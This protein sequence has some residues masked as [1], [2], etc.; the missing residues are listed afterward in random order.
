MSHLSNTDYNGLSKQVQ[1]SV[2][3]AR[4]SAMLARRVA[5]NINN[6]SS[7]NDVYWY[8][9]RTPDY[10][11]FQNINNS[12]YNQSRH[13]RIDIFCEQ[14]MVSEEDQNCCVCIETREKDEIGRFNCKHTFCGD[15]INNIMKTQKTVCCPICRMNITNITVQ[16]NTIQEKLEKL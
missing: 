8:I 6:A 14:F 10:S 15:C 2:C 7:N 12:A 9:D 3:V 4:I 16:K 5:T 13:H 1:K 11:I